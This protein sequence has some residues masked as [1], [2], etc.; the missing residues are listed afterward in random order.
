MTIA[1]ARPM[2]QSPAPESAPGL[3]VP[4]PASPVV[5]SATGPHVE[6]RF[7]TD[8]APDS[9]RANDGGPSL[10]VLPDE[11]AFLRHDLRH[12]TPREREVVLAICQGGTNEQ[13]AERLNIALPTLR[14]HL[15]RLNQKLGT[16]SKGDVVRYVAAALLQGYRT[17][18]LLSQRP[19]A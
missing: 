8:A 7:R 6:P 14:T 12:L 13:V 17:G 2:H 4:L 9:G 19:V 16:M 5:V 1:R 15:M 18:Q 10:T 3:E 11:V